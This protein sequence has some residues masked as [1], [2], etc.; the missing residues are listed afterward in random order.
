M[1]DKN[2]IKAVEQLT[3]LSTY[4]KRRKIH[5]YI[6]FFLRILEKENK[7]KISRKEDEIFKQIIEREYKHIEKI[8]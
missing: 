5:N 3:G 7:P 2:I 4:Q 1:N 6:N 8:I